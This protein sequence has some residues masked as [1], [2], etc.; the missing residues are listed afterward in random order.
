MSDFNGERYGYHMKYTPEIG[1]TLL[2]P[3]ELSIHISPEAAEKL[4]FND[5]R[6]IEI[7]LKDVMKDA[8]S[9]SF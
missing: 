3:G 7:M 2:R 5:V 4:N 1:Y 6:K 8:Q 9:G